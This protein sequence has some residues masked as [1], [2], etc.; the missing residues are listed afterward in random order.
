MRFQLISLGINMDAGEFTDR[1]EY[2]KIETGCIACEWCQFNCPVEGCFT[3]ENQT[4]NFHAGLCIECSRCIYVCP[5]D[6]IIP[7]R[8]AFPKASLKL[9]SGSIYF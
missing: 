5:V 3:F 6:V 1:I 2:L 7:L 8:K 9:R 4:A